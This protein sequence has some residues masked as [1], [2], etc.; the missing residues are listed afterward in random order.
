MTLN[1][2][3]REDAKVI[4]ESYEKFLSGA[5]LSHFEHQSGSYVTHRMLLTK[6]YAIIL[7]N[8][9]RS[10]V[11]VISTPIPKSLF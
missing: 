9:C 2:V 8:V 1:K 3:S 10:S 7:S 5:Y 11:K 6:T 4:A